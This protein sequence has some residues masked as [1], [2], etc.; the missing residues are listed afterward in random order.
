[1]RIVIVAFRSAKGGKAGLFYRE[2]KSRIERP[3]LETY[4]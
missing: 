1:M 3:P 4:L 2:T